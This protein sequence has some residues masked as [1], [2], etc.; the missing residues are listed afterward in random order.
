MWSFNQRELTTI[1]YVKIT[2]PDDKDLFN[3]ENIYEDIW[4][5]HQQNENEM[6]SH[7]EA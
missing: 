2:T 4:K 3:D 5:E 1:E 6:P 7:K